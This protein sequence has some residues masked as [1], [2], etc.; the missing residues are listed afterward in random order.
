MKRLS[1]LDGYCSTVQGLLAWV[2]V[3]LA[4]NLGFAFEGRRKWNSTSSTTGLLPRVLGSEPANPPLG[5]T[6]H[7]RVCE[8]GIAPLV[9]L[10]FYPACWGLN[11]PPPS[12]VHQA[13]EGLHLR[14]AMNRLSTFPARCWKCRK[15]P[16]KR[17][18]ILQKRQIILSILLTVATP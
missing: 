3:D 1:I 17:V 7:L 11:Q 12:W 8:S 10:G 6:K 14:V 13:F 15:E 18:N 16:C 5:F 2:E 4:F 9:P